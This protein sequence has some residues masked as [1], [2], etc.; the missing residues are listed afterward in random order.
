M[1][2]LQFPNGDYLVAWQHWH[3]NQGCRVERC[4]GDGSGATDP[5]KCYTVVEG[6]HCGNMKPTDLLFTGPNGEYDGSDKIHILNARGIE[7]CKMEKNPDKTTQYRGMCIYQTGLTIRYSKAIE[8]RNGVFYYISG[9][10]HDADIFSVPETPWQDPYDPHA[11]NKGE[12]RTKNRP[13][14]VFPKS[15]FTYPGGH[16]APQG[17]A[18]KNDD[19]LWVTKGGGKEVVL[20]SLS[21]KT[22][23]DYWKQDKNVPEQ[24]NQADC[25]LGA[26]DGTLFFGGYW[27]QVS[28]C[29]GPNNCPVILGG[30]DRKRYRMT[31]ADNEKGFYRVIRIKFPGV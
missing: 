23:T 1:S 29:S 5:N 26:D 16:T 3:S 7:T 21:T 19:E 30:P 18:F 20:C 25:L 24:Y 10:T 15:L 28:K 22:C 27:N 4:P 11:F 6:H 31:D 17:L 12:R 14:V 13:K 2:V 9:S 8:K